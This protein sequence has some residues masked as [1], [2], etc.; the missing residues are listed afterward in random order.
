[1]TDESQP[2][3][4]AEEPKRR[5][6]NAGK[7]RRPGSKNKWGQDLQRTILKSLDR[8]GGSRYLERM[9]NEQPAA[10]MGLLGKCVPREM[11]AEIT[12]ELTIRQEIRKN[13]VDSLVELIGKQEANV[14][15]VTPKR[16]AYEASE[17]I[18]APE[19]KERIPGSEHN[20]E[21][22]AKE[23]ERDEI[24]QASGVRQRVSEQAIT[25][26]SVEANDGG[27]YVSKVAPAHPRDV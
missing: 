2:T 18:E 23:A 25:R 15:D 4:A 3:K 13:L 11:R 17:T 10:Y 12:A 26:L 9:A 5:P 16:V 19:P 6:P 8:V 27:T 20:A 24:E 14:I 21:L 1:M 22:E 7:G